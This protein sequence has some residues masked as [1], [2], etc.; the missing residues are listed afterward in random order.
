M[1]GKR[2]FTAGVILVLSAIPAFAQ[3]KGGGGHSGGHVGGGHVGVVGHVGPAS[4][5]SGGY[6]GGYTGGVVLNLGLGLGSSYGGTVYRPS[7]YGNAYPSGS[8]YGPVPNIVSPGVVT[9]PPTAYTY[10]NLVNNPALTTPTAP[11]FPLGT[12]T[13]LR[14]TDLYE[15]TAKV[16]GLRKGDIIVKVNG[17][18]TQSFEELRATLSTGKD[19]V[20]VEYIDGTSGT[21]EKKSVGVDGTKIGVSVAEAAIPKS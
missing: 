17:T 19:K 8:Y 20:E 7:Y 2:I 16:A 11:A 15:G 18:R 3:H 21:T 10:P 6:R 12:E 13:G 4:I 9:A 14:I 5:Y 1:L